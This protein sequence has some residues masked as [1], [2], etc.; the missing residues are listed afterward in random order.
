M[1]YSEKTRNKALIPIGIV[2]WLGIIGRLVPRMFSDHGVYVSV[3][4]RLI[5]GDRL[6]SGV[7]DNK[8]PVFYWVMAIGR[9]VSPIADFVI[10][11]LWLITAC[12]SIHVISKKFLETRFEQQLVAYV[13]APIILTGGSYGAGMTHLPGEALLFASLAALLNNHFR[14]A[15]LL[16]GTLIFL[17]LIFL[18]L[19]FVAMYVLYRRERNNFWGTTGKSQLALG[20]CTSVIA[21]LAVLAVRHEFFPYIDSL[22]ENFLYSHSDANV[23]PD[24]LYLGRIFSHLFRV[25]SLSSVMTLIGI[26]IAICIVLLG[27]RSKDQ[28]NRESISSP[29]KVQQRTLLELAVGLLAASVVVIFFTGTWWHHA[30]I[31]YIPSVFL[32][33]LIVGIKTPNPGEIKFRYVV[34]I[35][36]VTLMF[37]GVDH[38][39]RYVESDKNLSIH[40]YELSTIQPLTKDLLKQSVKSSYARVGK[41]DG[42]GEAMGLGAWTLE[43]PRFAQYEYDLPEVLS[44]DLKCL[45]KAEYIMVSPSY[46]LRNWSRTP[47]TTPFQ[48]YLVGV[49]DLLRTQYTCKSYPSGDICKHI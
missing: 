30:Q 12:V 45:P 48:Y 46:A 4:E 35:A 38:P 41:N 18:P 19:V 32:V 3:A 5:A 28:L 37:A 31:Y 39:T 26:V 24:T 40:L 44:E 14:V 7:W 23:R 36:L 8:D 20:L 29:Q 13:L 27:M 11:I 25:L 17:K 2:T 16:I 47:P 9:S 6:Y 10:E 42:Y 49:Y 34:S 21:W 33:I 1:T 43:C 22:K 15:G